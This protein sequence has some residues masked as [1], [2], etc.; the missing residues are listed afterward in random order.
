MPRSPSSVC[1]GIDDDALESSEL[2][3]LPILSACAA[4]I[5][6]GYGRLD[7]QDSVQSPIEYIHDVCK[8]CIQHAFTYA[9]TRVCIVYVYIIHNIYKFMY[10]S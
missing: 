7:L 1:G 10:Y 2:K 8:L 4:R 5:Q 9:Y 6:F 3:Q